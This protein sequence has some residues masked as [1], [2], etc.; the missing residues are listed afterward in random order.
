MTPCSCWLNLHAARERLVQ[1][2][3]DQETPGAATYHNWTGQGKMN[4]R[5]ICR[6]VWGWWFGGQASRNFLSKGFW[7]RNLPKVKTL[8]VFL[9]LMLIWPLHHVQV[10]QNVLLHGTWWV[11]P[12]QQVMEVP[13]QYPKKCMHG[14]AYKAKNHCY[15]CAGGLALV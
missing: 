1:S 9:F 3:W 11:E 15:T 2:V 12:G 5:G 6:R 10:L 7:P 8:H 14:T 4:T 13:E